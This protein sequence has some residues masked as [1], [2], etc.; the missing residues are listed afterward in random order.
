MKRLG[1]ECVYLDISHKPAEF[2]RAHF[3]NI[4]AKCCLLYTSDA[5]DE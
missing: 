5:A 2:I 4:Y 3:P 1:A